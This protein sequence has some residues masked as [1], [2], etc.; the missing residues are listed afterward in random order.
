MGIWEFV[1]VVNE[2]VEWNEIDSV[3]P[4]LVL[5]IITGGSSCG[6][7][8]EGCWS[9]ECGKYTKFTAFAGQSTRVQNHLLIRLY[10]WMPTLQLSLHLLRLIPWSC[11]L[12]RA[13]HRC[14]LLLPR[15]WEALELSQPTTIHSAM[16]S[17]SVI[18]V[19]SE[20]WHKPVWR[21]E[22]NCKD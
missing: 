9:R 5:I 4:L 15:D 1:Q 8:N 12:A 2:W 21:I 10:K 7:M 19:E 6:R 16:L 14:L 13:T 22:G 17:V 3:R 18:A 20:K 11:L